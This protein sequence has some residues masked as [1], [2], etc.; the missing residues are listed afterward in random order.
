[1][2]GACGLI[3]RT[4][5]REWFASQPENEGSGF[6]ATYG[7]RHEAAPTFPHQEVESFFGVSLGGDLRLGVDFQRPARISQFWPS[8][9]LGYDVTLCLARQSPG[10]RHRFRKRTHTQGPFWAGFSDDWLLP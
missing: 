4:L 1:M 8:G 6:G 10:F 3:G 9:N 2:S 7:H 5:L